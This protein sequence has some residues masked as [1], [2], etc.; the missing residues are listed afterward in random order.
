METKKVLGQDEV[1]NEV[2]NEVTATII[3]LIQHE[4]E[5][6]EWLS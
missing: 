5:V 2:R 3:L 1:R 6:K 4:V